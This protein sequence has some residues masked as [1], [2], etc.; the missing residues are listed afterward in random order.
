LNNDE[1]ADIQS[2]TGEGVITLNQRLSSAQDDYD[3]LDDRLIEEEDFSAFIE[4]PRMV[5]QKPQPVLQK[6]KPLTA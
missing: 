6:P 2:E 1:Q 3:L 5:E 4:A